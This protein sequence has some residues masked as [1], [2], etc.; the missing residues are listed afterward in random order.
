MNSHC[1]KQNTKLITEWQRTKKNNPL[2]ILILTQLLLLQHELP[3]LCSPTSRPNDTDAHTLVQV[4]H[5]NLEA[6]RETRESL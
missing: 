1:L 6:L 3:V 2:F 4:L 5:K